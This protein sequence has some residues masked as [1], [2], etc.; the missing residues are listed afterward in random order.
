M[1]SWLRWQWALCSFVPPLL[2]E[3]HPYIF[4]IFAQLIELHQDALPEVYLTLL[5]GF[6][7]PHFWERQ[8]N[9]PALTRLM[10]VRGPGH[11]PVLPA[12]LLP[13]TLGAW[14]QCRVCFAGLPCRQVLL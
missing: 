12:V 13:E 3:F 7:S 1:R 9:V 14:D 4:Q 11:P 2:Q 5:P 8:G 10:Q 6:M